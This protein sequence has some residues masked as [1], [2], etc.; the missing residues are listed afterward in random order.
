M[1]RPN[2]P[3]RVRLGPFEFNLHAG[4]LRPTDREE[5]KILL[6]EQP[7]QILRMLVERGGKVVTREEIRKK[8]WPNDTIVDFNHSINVA[9]GIVRRALGDSAENPKY[10]ET[11]ARR[12]YRLMINPEPVLTNAGLLNPTLPTQDSLPGEGATSGGPARPD[13]MIGK[14]V[15]HYRVLELIG[16][17]GMGMV[18]RAEDL[19][20]GRRVAVKFLPPEVANEPLALRRFEREAR[21]AS[22]LNHPNICAIYEI[23]E[24]DGTPFIVMELL[25]GRSLNHELDFGAKLVPMP[26]LLEMALQIC[27]GLQ[28]A[29]EKGIIHRDIKPANI[30]LPAHGPAK[31]LD[32][33]LAKLIEIEED[34][35]AT[36]PATDYSEST[37]PADRAKVNQSLTLTGVAMGTAGYMSPEQIRR[38]KLDVT[39]DLFSFG[40]VLFEAATGRRAFSGETTAIIHTAILQQIP[41]STRRLNPAVPRRF[42]AV[43][44][45]A[46]EKER[47][48]RYQTASEMR[49]EIERVKRETGLTQVG[50]RNR[51][52]TGALLAVLILATWVY[53]SSSNRIKLS[54][55]DTVV[56]SVTNQTK[57]PVFNDAV[58]I[59]LLTSLQQTPYLSVLAINKVGDALGALHQA[60]DPSRISPQIARQV[61]LQ[62]SSRM[63]IAASISEAGNDFVIELAG[64]D[65]RSSRTIARVRNEATSRSQVVHVLGVSAAQ[66]R[67]KLGEPEASINQFNKPLDEATSA[68]PEALQL[69][70]EGYRRN[71]FNDFRGAISNYAR[72]VDLDPY[73]GRA[74]LALAGARDAVGERILAED[75]A[76]K[77]YDL[78]SRLTEPDR[79]NAEDLY[80]QYVTGD[81]EKR[82]SVL[83]RYVLTFPNDATAHYNLAKC[84]QFVGQPDRS[85]AEAR[86]S[87]RLLPSSVSYGELMLAAIST[88]RLDEAKA[89]YEGAKLHDFDSVFLHEQRAFLAFLERDETALNE[90][91][92]WAAGRPEANY[93]LLHGRAVIERYFGRYREYRRLSAEAAKLAAKEGDMVSVGFYSADDALNEA[94]AGDQTGARRIAE[95]AVVQVQNRETR[96]ILALA[97]ARAGDVAEAQT[98]VDAVGSDAPLDTLVQN[99]CLPSIRAA[100]K[101][102]MHDPAGA[103]D[104]LRPAIKYDL[105]SPPVFEN[106]YPAYLRGLAYLDMR[107]GRLAAAE[108]RKLLDHPGL[109]GMDEIG[110]LSYLQLARAEKIAGNES[111]A[112]K[113]YEDFLALW[114]DADSDLPIYGQA[115]TEYDNLQGRQKGRN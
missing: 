17:G 33:G 78:R 88:D 43:I 27:D 16:G 73:L 54:P 75:A 61:C 44:A 60:G 71:L 4:E 35:V 25:E 50:S 110:A 59:S 70:T 5:G 104:I 20:L 76:K 67:G 86:E 81:L 8:L 46:L 87:L 74:E 72:A 38:E 98:I 100:M 63:V 107:E 2:P 6:P 102:Q 69:L 31:I 32:F 51:L 113:S 10:I 103:V 55:S 114:K 3:D 12:G 30:F 101:L 36:S 29:H 84:L 93:N 115:R 40:V 21:A 91:W 85:L 49:A 64:N 48:R 68:S 80:H 45:K 22:T 82:C 23:E 83:V 52:T 99:Y 112:R 105:A 14:R 47:L 57:D 13:E 9:I 39:T 77:G 66:L 111:A 89:A 56:L 106:F 11:L 26:K 62:T 65:C 18:Y 19:R 28:A 96:L 1:E 7:Y 58:Y 109:N 37:D 34:E 92:H 53:W 79:L 41:A 94:E 42:D 108:F 24:H 15:S 95:N 97:F 90:Q